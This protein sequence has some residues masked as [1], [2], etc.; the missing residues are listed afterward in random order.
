MR[1]LKSVLLILVGL[2]LFACGGGGDSN[3]LPGDPVASTNTCYDDQ[4]LTTELT[5]EGNFTLGSSRSDTTQDLP[6]VSVS[7]DGTT[8]TISCSDDATTEDGLILF[9]CQLDDYES[10]F[11]A[12]V[13]GTVYYFA[14]SDEG[15]ASSSCRQLDV[16]C[17]QYGFMTGDTCGNNLIRDTIKPDFEHEQDLIKIFHETLENLNH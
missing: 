7:G 4:C 9:S 8:L 11:A 17:D 3:S 14:E 16:Y 1:K 5:T 10:Y 12:C 6:A 15:M 2:E 13:H